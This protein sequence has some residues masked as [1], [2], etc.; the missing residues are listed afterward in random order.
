M[1][2]LPN[3]AIRLRGP[4]ILTGFTTWHAYQ[5]LLERFR[6][7]RHKIIGFVVATTFHYR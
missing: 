3:S 7:L 2:D 1:T 4:Q 5:D 6:I